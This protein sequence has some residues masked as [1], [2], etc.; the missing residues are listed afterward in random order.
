[1]AENLDIEV[2]GSFCY[3]NDPENCKKY[4]RL[5]TWEAAKKACPKGWHLPS[6]A[7]W[8]ILMN[9]MGGIL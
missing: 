3:D 8:K 7:E 2:E 9:K 4:G 1:M 6:D 5:Y